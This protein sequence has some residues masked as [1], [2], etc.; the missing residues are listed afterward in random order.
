MQVRPYNKAILPNRDGFIFLAVFPDG[1]TKQDTVTR[2]EHGVHT[3]TYF[4]E[5]IGWYKIK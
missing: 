4:I 3:C 1:T 2:N 5:M